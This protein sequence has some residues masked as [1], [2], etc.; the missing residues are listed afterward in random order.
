M[1]VIATVGLDLAKNV[2]HLHAVD[3]AGEVAIRRQDRRTQVL[4]FLSRLPPCLIGIEACTW[5]HYWARELGKFGYKARLILWAKLV[6]AEVEAVQLR[7]AQIKAFALSRAMRARTD[8]IEAVI[9]QNESCAAKAKILRSIPASG[10][11]SAAMLIAQM[12]KLGRMAA[13][14]AAAMT[15]LAPVPHDSGTMRG[16]RAIAEGR[17]ALRHVLYQAALAAACHNPVLKPVAKR[18][19]GHGKPHKLVIMAIARRLVVIASVIL[20]TGVPWRLQHAQ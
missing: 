19:K 10:P 3:A 12:P 2:F 16:R 14:E 18:L 5:A 13:G 7:P 20:K 4:P 15:G 1:K 9:A 11:V 6:E 17:Q 8:R